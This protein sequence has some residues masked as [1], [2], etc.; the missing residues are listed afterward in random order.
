MIDTFDAKIKE[1]ELFDK[2]N[3][4]KSDLNKKREKLIKENQ[5]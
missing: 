2:Y 1:W 5:N 4:F 3:I